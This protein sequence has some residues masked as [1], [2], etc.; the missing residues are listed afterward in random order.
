MLIALFH[1]HTQGPL[2]P[3][4]AR[5][6]GSA[7]KVAIPLILVFTSGLLLTFSLELHQ[8]AAFVV[9]AAAAGSACLMGKVCCAL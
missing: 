2:M 6:G 9:L 1:M 3:L 7:G 5:L 8:M 4:T